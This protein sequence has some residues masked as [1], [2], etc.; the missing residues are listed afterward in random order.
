MEPFVTEILINQTWRR[1]GVFSGKEILKLQKR[2]FKIQ[3]PLATYI[4][5]HVDSLREEAAGVFLYV[6]HVMLEA[7]LTCKPKPRKVTA[8]DI[9]A[10]EED[11]DSGI[12]VN[13][14]IH[15]TMYASEAFTEADDVALGS[16]EIESMLDSAHVIAS[17]IHRSFS[18]AST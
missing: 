4:A 11:L 14:E 3:K 17:C 18:G 9:R 15:L 5:K 6:A 13:A 12:E 8:S 10:A 1:I 7:A 2:H 16:N